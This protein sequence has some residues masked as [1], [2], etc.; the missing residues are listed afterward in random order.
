[1]PSS[2]LRRR[3]VDT[4]AIS[5][6]APAAVEMA[7]VLPVLLFLLMGIIDFGRASRI[8]TD[9]ANKMN[10]FNKGMS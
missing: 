7:S 4:K 8:L 2:C 10:S 3:A 6:A 5:I 9:S 1:L